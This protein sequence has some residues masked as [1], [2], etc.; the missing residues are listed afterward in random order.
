MFAYGALTQI[1]EK[2]A[3]TPSKL[4]LDN[5]AMKNYYYDE[6]DPSVAAV[7]GKGI[8]IYKGELAV[9]TSNVT[10]NGNTELTTERTAN[11]NADNA[12]LVIRDVDGNKAT[13]NGV[14][15]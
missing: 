7:G 10:F 14:S 6:A 12:F 1:V 13:L 9:V 8:K 11:G 2:G 4:T 15:K 3:T 5:V